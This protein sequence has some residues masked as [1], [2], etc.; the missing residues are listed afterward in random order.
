MPQ[1][2]MLIPSKGERLADGRWRCQRCRW[3]GEERELLPRHSGHE[4][5]ITYLCPQCRWSAGIA[6]SELN[7]DDISA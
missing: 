5:Y 3:T 4:P 7:E 1:A 6:I 2:V